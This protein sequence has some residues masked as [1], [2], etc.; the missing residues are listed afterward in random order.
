[1]EPSLHSLNVPFQLVSSTWLMSKISTLIFNVLLYKPFISL[2]ICGGSILLFTCFSLLSLWEKLSSDALWSCLSV[3]SYELVPCLHL[4]LLFRGT[5]C[6]AVWGKF[7]ESCFP[8]DP[9]LLNFGAGISSPV[10]WFCVLLLFPLIILEVF[11]RKCV[12]IGG[13]K[14]SFPCQMQSIACFRVASLKNG[15]MC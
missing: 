13:C 7:A 6:F 2:C 14:H 10:L 8:L 9:Q 5:Q 1:M 11:R 4:H 15:F 3:P 12:L